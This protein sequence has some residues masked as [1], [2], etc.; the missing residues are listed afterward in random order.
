MKRRRVSFPRPQ[1]FDAWIAHRDYRF[2][3][4][5]NFFANTAHWLQLLTLGWLVQHLTAGTPSSALLVVG[6]GGM[7]MLPSLIVG[8]LGGVLG[9]RTDRRKLIM[10]IQ[11]LMALFRIRVR[12]HGRL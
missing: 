7:N 5:G 10:S 2:L 6:V 8:P 1:T 4:V 9:D 3:W 12:L 11:A